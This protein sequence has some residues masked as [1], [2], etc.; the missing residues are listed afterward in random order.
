MSIPEATRQAAE[1]HLQSADKK[2]AVVIDRVGPWQMKTRRQ[3]F[4]TLVRSI[5][6][7][8]ISGAAAR[9]I[10]RRLWKLL[11]GRP[12]PERVAALDADAL[13]E[14]G[15]SRQ[16]T[17]YLQDLA[18][19]ALSGAI[20]FRRHGR[21]SD[22]EVIAELIQVKGIGR[23]TAQMFLMFSLARLDVFPEDDLGIRA[24]IR[25]LYGLDD[26]PDKA[27]AR[28]IAAPWS[29]YRSAASWYLWRSLETEA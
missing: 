18:A 19:H 12:T 26:L 23:W 13:R 6:S 1:K 20:S 2:L 4:P 28:R 7:Q 22:E 3:R 9:T 16:K 15:L 24:A 5:V 27:T 11:E 8:Q 21:M 25:N 14:C 10:H 29:P 17:A